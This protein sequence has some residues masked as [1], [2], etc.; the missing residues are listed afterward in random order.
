MMFAA[1]IIGGD[2]SAPP[3]KLKRRSR[4]TENCNGLIVN[5]EV[6]PA[7]GIAQRHAVFAMLVQV[8]GVGRLIVGWGQ[9]V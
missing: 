5:A 8:P 4:L 6:F 3:P 7:N 9:R 1:V 2:A